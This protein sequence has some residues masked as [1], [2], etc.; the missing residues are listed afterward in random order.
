MRA[1]AALV[2][3]TALNL[4]FGTLYAFSIFLKPIEALMQTYKEKAKP[5]VA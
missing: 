5:S 3:A 4:P 1:P 2:A